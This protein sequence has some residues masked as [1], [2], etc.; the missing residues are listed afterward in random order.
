MLAAGLAAYW[1]TLQNP[2]VFDDRVLREDLLRHYASSW[3]QFDLRWFSY[4]SFGWIFRVF[5][6]DWFWQRLANVL[7]HGAVAAMLFGLVGRLVELTA[8]RSDAAIPRVVPDS[9]WLAFFGAAL[10]LLHP[11][12][13]Y[14]VAYLVQRSIVLATLFSLVSLRCFLE[15]LHRKAPG[16]HL[17]AAIAYFA[18]VFSKE[19][20]VMLPAVALALAVLV[21]GYSIRLLRD[22]WLPLALFAG[23][24]ALVTLKARGT[25]GAPYEPFVQS[26]PAPIAGVSP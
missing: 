13:A 18:A 4:A 26:A 5:G 16:W 12:A 19:H 7:L 9:R 23:I 2:L 14:G 22:L 20:A 10:F 6:E 24:A 21:R 25:L 17:A 15:G 1:G 8:P 3:F 11:V